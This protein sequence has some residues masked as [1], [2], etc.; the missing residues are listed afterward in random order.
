MKGLYRRQGRPHYVAVIDFGK[1]PL[2]QLY[3]KFY[4]ACSGLCYRDI[5][6]LSRSLFVSQRAIEAWKYK[7][8]FPGY[9][10]A[11]QVIEWV[12]QGKPMEQEKPG[13]CKSSM[14]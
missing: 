8:R 10:V 2:L 6:A 12:E 4:R 9:K 11:T 5:M 3:D 14:L 7:E 13:D 1:D